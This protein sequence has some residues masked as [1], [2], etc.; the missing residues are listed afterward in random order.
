MSARNE[1]LYTEIGWIP[2]RKG[3]I[4]V[5]QFP[6]A[7][8]SFGSLPIAQMNYVG[9]LLDFFLL[10]IILV[11]FKFILEYLKGKCLATEL[12]RGVR[13]L[14]GP[15]PPKS[16]LWGNFSSDGLNQSIK[17]KLWLIDDKSTLTWLRH[18]IRTAWSVFTGAGL[19]WPNT[20]GQYSTCKSTKL[21]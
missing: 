15:P 10:E 14:F 9:W 21:Q 6:Q 19:K 1:K 7:N 4:S 11:T 12:S 20:A 17:R 2:W 8:Q 18:W 3:G 13:S 5:N 16:F